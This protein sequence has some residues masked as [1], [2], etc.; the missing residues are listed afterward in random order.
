MGITA[1]T[2][3][4]LRCDATCYRS[5]RSTLRPTRQSIQGNDAMKR[6]DDEDPDRYDGLGTSMV[7]F[8]RKIGN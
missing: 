8:E 6:S 3:P 4:V 5:R 1:W 2:A 7:N